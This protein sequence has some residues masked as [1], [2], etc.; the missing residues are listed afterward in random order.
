MKQ[1]QHDS[2]VMSSLEEARIA[3]RAEVDARRMIFAELQQNWAK[4]KNEE[5]RQKAD[6]LVMVSLKYNRNYPEE[7]RAEKEKMDSDEE[8]R[9]YYV[10]RC[11]WLVCKEQYRLALED[12]YKYEVANGLGEHKVL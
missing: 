7:V 5:W 9:S 6:W 11:V 2:G 4:V 3:K 10:M 8:F 12:L 1:Q